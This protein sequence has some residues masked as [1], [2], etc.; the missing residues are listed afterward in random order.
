[1]AQGGGQAGGMG[2]NPMG[3][4]QS[5]TPPPPPQMG[6]MGMGGLGGGQQAQQPMGSNTPSFMSTTAQ[7]MNRGGNNVPLGQMLGQMGMMGGEYQGVIPTGGSMPPRGLPGST[8]MGPQRMQNTPGLIMNGPNMGQQGAQIPEFSSPYFQ[9]MQQMRQQQQMPQQ[10]PQDA[11]RQYQPQ[12]SL[13]PPQS[14]PNQITQS[15][16]PITPPAPIA[17]SPN[18]A[19]K[20]KAKV[21]SSAPAPAPV[22]APTDFSRMSQAG[23]F[24]DQGFAQSLQDYA[25]QQYKDY[26][27]NPGD[28]KFY[29]GGDKA[30]A[31]L[32]L[33]DVLRSGRAAGY[34]MANGGIAALRRR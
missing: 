12:V 25:G 5:M 1:M 19:K 4:Q 22:Q 9:Q 8:Q 27:Y 23:Q 20:R 11:M 16:S 13:P 33:A 7:D 28:Q 10:M 15:R 21:V 30:G 2:P 32:G 14:K 31:T 18:K 17:K 34:K 6:G 26:A 24:G 3:G 29:K